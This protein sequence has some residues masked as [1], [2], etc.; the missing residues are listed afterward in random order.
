MRLVI[1]FLVISAMIAGCSQLT[2]EEIAKKVKEKYDSI[3]DINGT[4]KIITKYP[5]GNTTIEIYRIAIKKPDKFR[6]DSENMSIISDGKTMWIYDKKR[7]EVIKLNIPE[8]P[9]EIDYGEFVEN[10]YKKNSIRLVGSENIN[11]RDCYIIEVTPKNRT[12]Y[13][14]QILWI[15]KE[16]WYPLRV[17]IDYGKFNATVEYNLTFNSGLSDDIF[18][19]TPPKGIK[20][21]KGNLPKKLTIEEARK[22]VNFTLIVPTYTA[23]YSFNYATVLK[24]NGM[25]RVILHYKKED[26]VLIISESKG[27]C[28]PLP[29]SDNIQIDN[30][31]GQIASYFGINVLKFSINNICIAISGKLSKY[32]LIKIAES[33]IKSAI[34]FN[35]RVKSFKSNCILFILHPVYIVGKLSHS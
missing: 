8:K 27:E 10:M 19:F 35:S 28:K 15:D 21:V 1:L 12:Y 32:E 18:K 34:T 26:K 14:K 33:M 16:Y 3:A 17:Y 31:K 6:C 22:N 5:N 4:V 25:E 30:V 13:V 29:N 20:I 24:V 7:S 23:D 11:S 2:A 9:K